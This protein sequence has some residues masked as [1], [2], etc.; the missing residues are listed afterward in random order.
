MSRNIFL[1]SDTHFMH[2]NMLKFTDDKGNLIR[3]S[4]FQSISQ[5]DEY[6]IQQWNE[7]VHPHDIIYHLGDVYMGDPIRADLILSRLMGRKR[8][9]LGNHDDGKDPVLQKHFQKIGIWRI[10]KEFNL[11]LT[12]VPIHP[13]SFRKVQYNVHGHIHQNDAPGDQYRNVC[14]EKTNY[15]PINIESLRIP[16]NGTTKH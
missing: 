1:I 6:M 12:H 15:A 7:T 4:R 14:V 5:H 3:G 8:L 9:I 2:S 16:P 13:T 10:F 11:V